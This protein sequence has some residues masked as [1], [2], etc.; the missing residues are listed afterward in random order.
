MLKFQKTQYKTKVPATSAPKPQECDSPSV[1]A[2]PACK[3]TSHDEYQFNYEA[4]N[5]ESTHLE[6]YDS[7][8]SLASSTSYS[9]VTTPETFRRKLSS[10]VQHHTMYSILSFNESQIHT[11][12]K[13]DANGRDLTPL[14]FFNP[15]YSS[16]TTE[17]CRDMFHESVPNPCLLKPKMLRFDTRRE[18]DSL[19]GASFTSIKDSVI[20]QEAI[21][22]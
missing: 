4:P 11:P 13:L 2:F 19:Y 6:Q 15:I 18:Q 3:V 10:T 1:K 21:F 20:L 14:A 9:R 5:C 16:P 17:T 12:S 22:V 7:C 8:L